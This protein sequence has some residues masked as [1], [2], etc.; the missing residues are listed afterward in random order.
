MGA[1]NNIINRRDRYDARFHDNMTVCDM[2]TNG[3][4][5]WPNEWME[6]F[7]EIYN[8]PIPTLISNCRDKTKWKDNKGNFVD[9]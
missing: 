4:W 5:N 7:P 9:F 8:I 1:L 6:M 2:V 3:G